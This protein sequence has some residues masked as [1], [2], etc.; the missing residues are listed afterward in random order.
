MADATLGNRVEAI[1]DSLQSLT[2][3]APGMPVRAEDWNTVVGAVIDVA[4]LMTTE[5]FSAPPHAHT[6]LVS[7]E[8]L[9]PGLVDFV[10][11]TRERQRAQAE[12]LS[13]L[14]Q[15]LGRVELR[16]AGID[17]ALATL[18]SNADREADARLD[19]EILIKRLGER[20]DGHDVIGSQL[21][22]LNTR[23]GKLEPR[24]DD[25]LALRRELSGP[26]GALPDIGQLQEELKELGTLREN[27]RS[28]DGSLGRL[29]D[30]ERRLTAVEQ[31]GVDEQQL[32][33]RIESAV[34]GSLVTHQ[35]D[36]T[37]IEQAIASQVEPAIDALG[38][39]STSVTELQAAVG[40]HGVRF[41]ASEAR[42]DALE[43]LVESGA[44]LPGRVA[45][46]DAFRAGAT[47]TLAALRA[48]VDAALALRDPVDSLATELKA[49]DQRLQGV[50][51][52]SE[53]G[54]FQEELKLV[55]T[56][57]DALEVQTQSF[58]TREALLELEKRLDG[59]I[60]DVK[61]VTGRL[62]VLQAVTSDL[63]KV[64]SARL[65]TVDG[66]VSAL[67]ETSARLA[68]DVGKLG[69]RVD[70]MRP[71]TPGRVEPVTPSRIEPVTPSRREG[72]GGR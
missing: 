69:E 53:L 4:R 34:E 52:A 27:L 38:G 30:L 64:T 45:A 62:D 67:T 9:D 16:L 3:M 18:Q 50:A 15:R 29:R 1:L 61:T 71:V 46:L 28:A 7:R 59:N 44:D 36:R 14:E 56:R 42:F 35:L 22:D 68:L 2:R 10:D 20:V 40:D 31:L 41:A 8:W 24:L 57:T 5:V 60:G 33:A 37:S 72:G 43:V 32:D 48:D 66:R 19:R 51:L 47:G 58:A 49:I 25:A 55:S 54:R 21:T 63:E 17:Q 11:T 6:G 12:Q 23:L 65:S 70:G 26:T 13:A 39:L